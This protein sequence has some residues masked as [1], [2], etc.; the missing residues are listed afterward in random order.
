MKTGVYQLVKE[1]PN[2]IRD[3][4]KWDIPNI[5]NNFNRIVI[6]G[7]GGSFIAGLMFK[8]FVKEELKMPVEVYCGDIGF[9]DE[10]TLVVLI[11]YSGNTKEVMEVFKKVKKNRLLIVSSG[12]RLVNLAQKN[13]KSV[14]EIPADLHPRFT[15]S[16]G[17]FPLLKVFEK[18]GIIENKRDIVKKIIK[19]LKENGY[20]L[21]KEAEQLAGKLKNK[22]PLIYASNY[23]YPAA[24]RMQ[25]SLEEDIKTLAHSNKITELFHNE[26]EALPNEKLFPILIIDEKETTAFKGQIKYFRK[27]VKE[28]YEFDYKEFSREER[29]FLFI[30]FADFFGYYLSKLK[31][32]PMGETPKSDE[33]KKL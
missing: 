27:L 25:T 17:L 33:I 3:S 19:T 18:V 20:K 28:F 30:Y 23:F 7:M 15:F 13:K 31:K 4:R 24:Y 14:V 22:I 1:F 29:V 8:E 12:G 32:T 10:K 21:D 16:Y 5:N 6:V 11:S 2:R 9:I 26:L